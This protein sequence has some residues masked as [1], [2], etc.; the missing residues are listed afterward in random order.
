MCTLL[1]FCLNCKMA[2]YPFGV[3][4][5]FILKHTLSVFM[6]NSCILCPTCMGVYVYAC[7]VYLWNIPVV[8]FVCVFL[9][10]QARSL[11][12]YVCKHH[13]LR[14]LHRVCICVCVCVCV[15]EDV[16]MCTRSNAKSQEILSFY[17]CN[18][19]CK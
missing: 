7:A 8:C 2:K 12:S 18:N 14:G 4:C 6:Q 13:A 3:E 16:F 5:V 17:H 9:P 1:E 10:Q 19:V 15:S 11:G